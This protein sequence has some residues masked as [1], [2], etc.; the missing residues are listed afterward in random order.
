MKKTKKPDIFAMSGSG[1]DQGQNQTY[2][3]FKTSSN[4]KQS[5]RLMQKLQKCSEAIDLSFCRLPEMQI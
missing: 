1:L 3:M 4:P 5:V 2:F